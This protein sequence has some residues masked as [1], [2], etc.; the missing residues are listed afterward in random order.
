LILGISCADTT[1]NVRR[2]KR[3]NVQQRGLRVERK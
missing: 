1:A 2:A 3:I